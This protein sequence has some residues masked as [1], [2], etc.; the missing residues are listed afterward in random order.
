MEWVVVKDGGKGATLV[1]PDAVH[2]SPGFTVQVAD[3]VG[4]G[5]SFA[6][7]VVLGYVNHLDIG[8]TLRLANAVGAATATRKGAGRNVG[9]P[10]TVHR[11]LSGEGG[12]SAALALLPKAT[13]AKGA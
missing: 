11:L 7:A 8:L 4:C 6:A 1:T 12:C 3:T 2:K 13:T 9:D 5:D 10:A